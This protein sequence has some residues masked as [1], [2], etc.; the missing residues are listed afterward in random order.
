[1]EGHKHLVCH[2]Q[3]EWRAAWLAHMAPWVCWVPSRRRG[4]EGDGTGRGGLA[5]S[6][7]TWTVWL[8]C[9]VVV[10]VVV[11]AV[12]VL[13]QLLNS[14]CMGSWGAASVAVKRA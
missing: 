2:L 11:V 10:A 1:M 5:S 12:V 4:P 7:T 6:V 3:S 13:V 9:T 14:L 8:D